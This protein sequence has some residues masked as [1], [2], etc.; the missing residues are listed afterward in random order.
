MD[1][2]FKVYDNEIGISFR[3]QKTAKLIQVIFRDIGFHLSVLEIENFL[4][5]VIDSKQKQVC[6]GCQYG[7]DC[8]SMLLRTPSSKVSIAVSLNEL[9]QIEDL[10][11]GTLF[12][13]DL[14]QYLNKVCK[15]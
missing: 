3:W 12:Q 4:D 1:G 11:R 13:A 6:M 14:E 7:K 2:V 9:N 15:N 5:Q 8:R 10:L